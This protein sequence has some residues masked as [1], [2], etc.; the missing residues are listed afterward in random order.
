M[1]LEGHVFQVSATLTPLQQVD[2]KPQYNAEKTTQI[3]SNVNISKF[4]Q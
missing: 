2:P 1:D 3:P 4:L